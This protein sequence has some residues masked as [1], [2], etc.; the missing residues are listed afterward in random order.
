MIKRK[1]DKTLN[2]TELASP[3]SNVSRSYDSN[4]VTQRKMTVQPYIQFRRGSK[5]G[6]KCNSQADID[7]I[8][9]ENS[10]TPEFHPC[11]KS[12]QLFSHFSSSVEVNK[13]NKENS[14]VSDSDDNKNPKTTEKKLQSR[15]KTPT[16]SINKSQSLSL[17]L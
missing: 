3:F 9:E 17:N 1:L 6:S 12:Q 11:E 13:Q 14:R 15:N 10:E 7:M 16:R 4:D 2:E 8:S 5:L